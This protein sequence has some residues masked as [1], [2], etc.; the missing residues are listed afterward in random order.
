MSSATRT[1]LSVLAAA[2]TVSA[3]GYV[4][5]IVVNGV[6]YSGYDVTVFPYESDPPI[7]VGWATTAT[8]LGFVSPDSYAGPDIICHENGTNAGGHAL[9]AAGDDVFLQWTAWPESHKGP[10]LDY[11]APCGAAGCETVDKTTLEFF[12]I[13]Q[14]GLVDGSTGPPGEYGDDLLIAN[15]NGWMVKIPEDIK[16]GFYVLRHEIIALHSA[17]TA[18][19]AQ[20]YP[21]CINLEITG[22]GTQ[23]PSG[24]LG[25]ELYKPSDAG[26][27]FNIYT[28]VTAYPVPGPS[29]IAGA[30]ALSSQ[31]SSSIV[32]SANAT[33]GTALAAAVSSG[34]WATATT[35]A[36]APPTTS[37]AAAKTATS[38][39]GAFVAS[40]TTAATVAATSAEAETSAAAASTSAAS[41]KSCKAK[42]RARAHEHS[43]KARAH[44]R[45]VVV[46]DGSEA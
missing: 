46:V 30:S 24:V 37:P 36:T 21:Q 17:E 2:A 7:V 18:D 33:V 3:H 8:D 35:A 43:N 1:L 14:V 28:S 27:L 29:V 26:I 32:S 45:D 9:V 42:R 39:G 6:S 15:G 19:G 5:N 22:T 25:T 23:Q 34:S 20:N 11:L 10:V 4:I 31:I 38:G 44:A 16:P 12:K 13:D 41:G 40:T